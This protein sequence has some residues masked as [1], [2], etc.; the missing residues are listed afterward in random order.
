MNMEQERGIR[1]PD[2]IQARNYNDVAAIQD[3]NK[4]LSVTTD[5]DARCDLI[6]QQISIQERLALRCRDYYEVEQQAEPGRIQK[7][8]KWL[9]NQVKNNLSHPL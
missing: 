9:G 1:I 8:A 6:D 5:S 3:I 4:L 2:H 7:A